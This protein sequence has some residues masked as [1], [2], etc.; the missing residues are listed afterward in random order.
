VLGVVAAGREAADVT[1]EGG[2]ATVVA[3]REVA[4]VEVRVVEAG[5]A[6]VAEELPLPPFLQ[7]MTAAATKRRR[8]NFLRSMEILPHLERGRSIRFRT[9]SRK[10]RHRDVYA[11]SEV[12]PGCYRRRSPRVESP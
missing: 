6:E 9:G 1:G 11:S 5:A 8:G 2:T 12:R 10:A 4:V 7:P 3:L